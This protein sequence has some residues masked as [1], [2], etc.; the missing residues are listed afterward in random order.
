MF[1]KQ[2]TMKQAYDLWYIL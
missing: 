2:L 1:L